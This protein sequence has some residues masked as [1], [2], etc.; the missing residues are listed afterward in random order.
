MQ[1]LVQT[2]GRGFDQAARCAGEAVLV[3]HRVCASHQGRAGRR[4]QAAAQRH[5]NR[6]V[7]NV[8]QFARG[9]QRDGAKLRYSETNGSVNMKVLGAAKER[10][11]AV[12]RMRVFLLFFSIS[13]QNKRR[14]HYTQHAQR[15]IHATPL[16]AYSHHARSGSGT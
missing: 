8:I 11:P 12:T 5:R 13:F 15:I 7:A 16:P 6:S 10:T 2:I 1:P 14:S 3:L 4:R 9:P